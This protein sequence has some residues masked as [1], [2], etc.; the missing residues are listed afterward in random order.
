MDGRSMRR[1]LIYLLIIVAITAIVFTLF[2]DSVGGSQE[3][4]INEVVSLA[5]G[6]DLAVIEIRGNELDILTVSGEALTSRKEAEASV[7]ELLE[8]AG[9]D[10]LTTKIEIVVKGSSGLSSLFGILFN[11]LPLV[12]FGAILLFMMRQAQGNSN[13]TFS[14]GRSRARVATGNGPT[15]SFDDVAGVEEAKEELLEVVEFLKFPERFLALG[16][17]IPKGVLLIGP[18]GT[19]KTLM[20]RAVSGEAGVPFFSISGSEFV[21]MFVGVGASRVRDL[22]DQAKRNSP[23]IVFVD[24]I[25]AVGRHRGAGLGGGHDEREQTLN[26]IL[27]EMDGFDTAT[28][29][30]VLAAT[31]RPDILDPALLR[32]G[33][34]D[35]RVT[36]DNPDIRGRKQILEVHSKGKP[37]SADV[38]LELVARQTVGFSGADLANLVNESAILAARQNQ[39]EIGPQEFYESIDRVTAGPARKSRRINDREKRMT[40]YHESGHALVAHMLP[41]ADPVVKVTIVARGHSGGF[42]KTIPTEDRSLIT[43]N[44]L[45]A[46]LAMAMGGRVAEELVFGEITT[47][48]SDDLEQATNIAQTMVTRYGMSKKLGPRTFGKREEMLFLGREISEQRDYSDRVA[49]TIDEEVRRLIQTAY[50]TAKRILTEERVRLDHISDYLLEHETI[51]EEQVPDLFDAPFDAPPA[52]GMPAVPAPVPGD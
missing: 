36:L 47:G 33:R 48:A 31:N 30:I 26:Q 6:G 44:Q 27:V 20:A 11:F 28:N 10:P 9:V 19:G 18:P 14:F 50:D 8:R 24:E 40:A 23:C 52:A 4:S 38:D 12:F 1:S 29:V 49:K 2:S 45:E 51:D 13:Q 15:V 22:F 3:I 42:T 41:E 5:A 37:L 16:A 32:P 7:V 21:E 34:F 35:R 39:K 17:K 25:D 43:R 46:R